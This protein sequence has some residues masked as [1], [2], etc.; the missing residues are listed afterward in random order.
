M[1]VLRD[2]AV[3]ILVSQLEVMRQQFGQIFGVIVVIFMDIVQEKD[4][5]FPVIDSVCLAAAKHGIH[6]GGILS[7]TVIP[8]KHPVLPT[9]RK[10]ADGIF[11]QIITTFG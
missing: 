7:G 3:T 8:T 5:P 11:R 2:G 9:D 4:E 1:I 10:R 6:N